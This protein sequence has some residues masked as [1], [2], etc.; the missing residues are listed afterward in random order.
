MAIDIVLTAELHRKL[1]A[2]GYNYILIKDVVLNKI[3]GHLQSVHITVHKSIPEVFKESCTGIDDAMIV[4]LLEQ[5][6]HNTVVYLVKS[7]T[8]DPL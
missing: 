6:A 8:A 1:K 7:G 5:Q 4:N 3:S 2:E